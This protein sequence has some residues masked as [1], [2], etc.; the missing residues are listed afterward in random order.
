[1]RLRSLACVTV[2]VLLALGMHDARA[3]NWPPPAGADLT[4]PNNWPN[5]PDYASDWNYWSWIPK[6]VASNVQP[7]LSADLKLGASGMRIDEAWQHSIGR[8][9]VKIAIVDCGI[10][11][12]ES[13]LANKEYLNAAELTGT[14][15]KNRPQDATGTPCPLIDSTNPQLGYDCPVDRDHKGVFTVSDYLADPR[16]SPMVPTTHCTGGMTLKGDVNQNCIL[17]AGDLI[18]LFSDKVDDDN[19]GYTDDISGWDFYKNDNNPYDDTR[20]GHGSGEAKM[21]SAEG[22]NMN[23]NIGVCPNCRFVMM[24]AGDSFIADATDFAK[25]VVY[26]ADNGFK[27]VQEA[28]GTIDQT[29]FSKAAIDYAYAHGTAVI[30]SMA[31]ENSRHH[32]MPGL[33][34]HTLPVHSMKTDANGPQGF[35]M[36]GGRVTTNASTFLAFDAC[37]NYG[38]QNML[39]ISAGS[40]SS[41]ATGRA[42]GL[43]GLLFSEGLTKG[44]KPDLSPEE[45]M[46]L[47]KMNA[48]VVDVPE[49]RSS[50]PD[51]SNLYYESLPYFS[52]RFGYGRPNMKNTMEA[53]D[54][55]KIPPEVDLLSP[56]WFDVL[57]ADRITSPVPL[58]GT[59]AAKRAQSYDYKVEWAPGVEP[60]D[61]QFQTLADWMRNVPPSTVTGGPSAPLAM[62]S[63]GQLNTTHVPDPDSNKFGENDRTITLRVTAIAHYASGD[64]TGQARRAIAIVNQLPTTGAD[65]GAADTDSGDDEAGIP[66]ET[67]SHNGLDPDLAQGF[68]IRMGA[69]VETSPKLADINGD[70]VRD[71]VAASSD[72]TL[73]V[74]S[75]K[76]GTPHDLPGFPFHT[77]V[78]DALN[79]SLSTICPECA[80][81]PSYITA[82]AYKNGA[83]GGGIDP[84]IARESIVATPA[85]G[86]FNGDGKSEIVVSSYQGTIYVID[87]QGHVLSGWPKRLPLIPSCP[88]PQNPTMS[89]SPPCM[90]TGHFWSRGTLASPVLADFDHDGKP[91]IVQAA[92][93]GNVYI[94]HGDGTPLAGWPVAIHSPGADMYNRIVSTPAVGDFNGDGIPDVVTGSNE[95]FGGGAG[96]TGDAGNIYLIDG[97]GMNTPGGAP[98][99]KDWPIQIVTLHIFPLVAEGT[100]SAPAIGDFS[101]DGK[102]EILMQGNSAGPPFVLPVDPGKQRPPNDPPNLQPVYHTDA[103]TQVGFDPS[104]IFG[105]G[106]KA[107]GP[108]TMIPLFSHPSIGDLDE[109]GVP[110]AITAGVSLSW[111][112]AHSGG[113]PARVQELLGMWSGA[114]GHMMWGSPVPIEDLTFLVNEAIADITGDGY[115]E[116]MIGT[117]GYFVRAV[118]ACG[119]E[120]PQ[121]PKF[122]NGWLIASPA[123]GDIDGDH[124]V[125][126]VTGTRDGYLFAWH[127]PGTDTGVI[128][129]ESFHHDNANTGNYMLKLDQGQLK[130]TS[131]PI[132]CTLDC[133]ATATPASTS[134]VKAGGC[135]CRTISAQDE[136]AG[137]FA[138]ALV[139]GLGALV[140]RR[141]RR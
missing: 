138:L 22:N 44:L 59:I 17:D 66:I 14:S 88:L 91:E 127:T 72:G 141:R 97:R 48:E 24:R 11:W 94:W 60:A 4:D 33:T 62:L 13:D 85:I 74:F 8:P 100:D 125:E 65:A 29:A 78:I 135:G 3:N 69:S 124:K 36:A 63:P 9:D 82:P 38:G 58:I 70:G 92:F 108:D 80:G 23:G 130:T 98:F 18:Q 56:A 106:T 102:P 99:F 118:D 93:D 139:A 103:G 42:A 2:V 46:Q 114:T 64:V 131:H 52:Q 117:G 110:D 75:L 116:V 16:I 35:Q 57:Y 84:A 90:D 76:G 81:V 112:G 19:N 21:S 61:A 55:G 51:V 132:D 107:F 39:S 26:A 6:Q 41:E 5:D 54:A 95:E 96:Q 10:Q 28:L 53:L 128:Q 20:Y 122:T 129:W 79:T 34:N 31:D 68:P 133:Q 12:D 49:S 120:A 113:H 140:S 83:Q 50:N 7:Y 89:S 73:H 71:I 121:W 136:R 37:S 87:S 40:C 86:D 15:G 25:G 119:C 111:V 30:A 105:A 1:M 104:V 45:V 101:G 134:Q 32:N 77:N 67:I 115:P 43:A 27:V 109:D 137:G 123:V 126:V 47:L